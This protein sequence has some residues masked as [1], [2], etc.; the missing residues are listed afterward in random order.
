[1][2]AILAQ[3]PVIP[4]TV[5]AK[6]NRRYRLEALPSIQIERRGSSAETLQYYTQVLVDAL[7]PII[8]AHPEQWFQFASLEV[9][10]PSEAAPPGP[11]DG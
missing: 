4:V 8:T 6:P 10:R 2:L 1:L 5:V 9:S 7:L 11:L 3:C